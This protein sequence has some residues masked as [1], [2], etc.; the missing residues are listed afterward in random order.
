MVDQGR[1]GLRVDEGRVTGSSDGVESSDGVDQG[2]WSIRVDQGRWSIRVDE[3]RWSMRVD[4]GRS[5]SMVD[6]RMTGVGCRGVG[7][8]RP[9]APTLQPAN[10][11]KYSHDN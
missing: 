11:E 3:G 5:G 1:S 9:Y 6:G 4:E 8:I 2:R 7:V 10:A